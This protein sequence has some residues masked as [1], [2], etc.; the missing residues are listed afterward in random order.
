MDKAAAIRS[1]A[2]ASGAYRDFPDAWMDELADVCYDSYQLALAAGGL[3]R[4]GD[5]NRA[6]RTL[7][8]AVELAPENAAIRFQLAGVH[9][10]SGELAAARQQLQSCTNLAPD[11]ADAWAHLSAL[12]EQA[13]DRAGAESV[14]KAGLEKCP[15]SPG[16]H[17]MHAR[18]QRKAGALRPA[19]ESYERSLQLR[20]NEADPHVELATLLFQLDRNSEAV[21]HLHRAL[22]AEPDHPVALTVLTLHAISGSD[23]SAAR[24]WL[25]RVR[26]QPRVAVPQVQRLLAAYRAQFQREFP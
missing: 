15:N 25:E 16:L 21:T 24:R 1:R 10:K 13:G 3:E 4:G 22:E 5:L 8:R 7:E 14:L 6:T 17:L 11:F 20:A 12:H 18:Q 9:V 2:K 19:V 23:E 26:A